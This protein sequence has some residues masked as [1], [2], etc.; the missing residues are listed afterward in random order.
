MKGLLITCSVIVLEV[1]TALA[2]IPLTDRARVQATDFVNFYLG[3]SIVRK[4]AGANLY[5]PETQ[6]AGYQSLL[7]RRSN[8]YFLHPPFEAALLAPLTVLSLEHAFIVWT[9]INIALLGFLPL[10][11]MDCIPLLESKPYAGMLGFCLLPTLTALT[12]GQDSILLL[13]VISS[14]Y[15]FLC[16]KADGTAGLALALAVIK[17]QYVVILL[18]LLLLTRR[19]RLG[20]GFG[21]GCVCLAVLSSLITGWHGLAGY[22]KFVRAFDAHSGYGGL[23][24]ALMTN[25]RGFFAGMGWAAG[26]SAYWLMGILL[27]GMGVVG[28]WTLRN[29]PNDGLMFAL[30][31]TIALAATPYSHFPDLTVMFLPILLALNHLRAGIETTTRRC[32]LLGCLAMF[33]W[34]FLLLLLGGHFWWN[35]R[36]YLVFPLL[37]LF[38]GALFVEVQ[39]TRN[40]S[41]RAA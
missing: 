8:Q 19:W 6:E 31:L 11:L 16:K 20:A 39:L 30:F 35:S 21:L 9:L 24:P 15:A 1:V 33:L 41:L 13:F 12:L 36:I 10:I 38:I 25:A 5:Q 40:R 22:F 4:G 32:L 23:N 3:A 18:P 17:F 2:L 7:G 34:P 29:R 37:V 26:S 28:A 27:I 14:S